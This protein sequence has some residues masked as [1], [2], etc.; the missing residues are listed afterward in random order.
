MKQKI[1]NKIS[2]NR[3]KSLR[4]ITVL[5]MILLLTNGTFAQSPKPVK[6]EIRLSEDRV[7]AG[8][9]LILITTVTLDEGWHIYAINEKID[10]PIATVIDVAGSGIIR[11]VGKTREPTPI[12]KYDSGFQKDTYFHEGIV[13]FETPI[14][15]DPLIIPG[16]NTLNASILYQACNAS[17]CLPPKSETAKL[18]FEISTGFGSFFLLSISMGLLALLTPCVFPMIPITISY[19]TKQGEIEGRN[20]VKQASVYSAGIIATYTVL[21]LLLAVTLGASGAN[22]L[23]ASPWV[24]LFIGG[25]FIYFA[26]SLFG[27]YEIELPSALRQFTLK[28]EGRGGYVGTLFMALTFTLTSF[29]CTV[30]FVGLLLVRAVQGDWFWPALGMLI[31]SAAF[32]LPFFFLALFP[33]YLARMPKSGGWLNSVKVVMGF[34]ELA[35]AFKFLSNTDLVWQ[36]NIFTRPVVLTVWVVIVFLTGLYILGKIRLPH[37]TPLETIGVPR[38]I[39]SIIL[40]TFSIYMARGIIGQPIHGLID[41]Y[42]P[43]RIQGGM[44]AAPTFGARGGGPVLNE[45][46]SELDVSSAHNGWIRDYNEGVKVAE[47]LGKP[48]F[49]NFTGIT[50]TNCRWMETN[51]FTE[52]EVVELFDNFVLIELFT[53]MGP[54]SK[55]W[56]KMEEQRFGTVA[57]PYYVILSS[58]G[59]EEIASFAGMTPNIQQFVRFLNLGLSGSAELSSLEEIELIRERLK[60]WW[61]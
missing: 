41:S 56:Q 4:P 13:V 28:Q 21:G 60:I 40:L 12:K 15:L 36:W 49:L 11:S 27:M 30:Q 55:E 32:A 39:L 24:N 38:L 54:R 23:A 43:P 50:C 47:E 17:L 46:I 48:I 45:S 59:Q 16:S 7:T 18:D 1:L 42:L 26:L 14:E 2:R 20:P 22:Q 34:L 8:D 5:V 29:T 57:L 25:L 53:D 19:F 61:M 31:F 9:Q 10:G 35:A 37:D 58:D 6:V 44:V 51:M 52:P 3:F 33:Q